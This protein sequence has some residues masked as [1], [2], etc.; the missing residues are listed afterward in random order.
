[1]QHLACSILHTDA[2]SHILMN[3]TYKHWGNIVYVMVVTLSPPL[4]ITVVTVT[5]TF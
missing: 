2:K 4:L 5:S 1:M 3:W